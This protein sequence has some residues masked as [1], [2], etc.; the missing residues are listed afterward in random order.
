MHY[1]GAYNYSDYKLPPF[2][3]VAVIP[4]ETGGSTSSKTDSKSVV[5]RVTISTV[6]LY[7]D[8]DTELCSVHMQTEMLGALVIMPSYIIPP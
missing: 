2:W 6:A 3:Y 4:L 1:N 8:K 5:S 7:N